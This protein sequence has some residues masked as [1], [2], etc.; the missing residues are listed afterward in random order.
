MYICVCIFTYMHTPLGVCGL[1][2]VHNVHVNCSSLTFYLNTATKEAS[3]LF[4][5]LCVFHH[6]QCL[7]DFFF[8]YYGNILC[9]VAPMCACL[10]SVCVHQDS[11]TFDGDTDVSGNLIH[12][13]SEDKS[14]FLIHGKDKSRFERI[15]LSIRWRFYN[16]M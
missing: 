10:Y 14:S 5:D 4:S 8:C 1:H 7:M 11:I 9:H 2:H 16:W 12:T 6:W 15:L 13:D 3:Q